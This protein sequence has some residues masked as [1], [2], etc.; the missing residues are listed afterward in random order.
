MQNEC[1]VFL[2]Q[3]KT[4]INIVTKF[5]FMHELGVLEFCLLTANK[6]GRAQSVKL[7]ATGWTTRV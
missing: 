6:R 2:V 3:T 7:L 5:N 4:H 1:N